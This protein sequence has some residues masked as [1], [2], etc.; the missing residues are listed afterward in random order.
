MT[1]RTLAP[2]GLAAAALAAGLIACPSWTRAAGLD[3]WNLPELTRQCDE[4]EAR[5]DGLADRRDNLFRR[6][7]AKR[8]AAAELA[9]GRLDL[10]GA[11][12]EFLAADATCPVAL[13]ALRFQFRDAPDQKRAARAVLV[14]V[15]YRSGLPADDLARLE[16][17]FRALYPTG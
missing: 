12:A 16:A 6:N 17:E 5:R 1:R 3:V 8:A 9:A 7:A 14:W 15:K 11:A 10:A 2:A 4:E 13:E